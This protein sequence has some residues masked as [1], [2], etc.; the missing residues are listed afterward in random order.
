MEVPALEW[1][2][3]RAWSS[4]LLLQ[5]GHLSRGTPTTGGMKEPVQ[6]PPGDRSNTKEESGMVLISAC[7]TT[8]LRCMQDSENG[9][10]CR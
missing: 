5:E 8:W 3:Q 6:E 1:S 4:P 7:Y 2:Q 10:P 9:D